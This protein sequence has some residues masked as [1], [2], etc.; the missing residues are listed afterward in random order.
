MGSQLP[1]DGGHDDAD[2][3]VEIQSVVRQVS[4]LPGAY[5]TQADPFNSRPA[6]NAPASIG[7]FNSASPSQWSS[8]V[9]AGLAG[10]AGLP[11]FSDGPVP[12]PHLDFNRFPGSQVH[13]RS[14][15]SFGQQSTSAWLSGNPMASGGLSRNAAALSDIISRTSMYDYANGIDSFGNP[16][17]DRLSEF[18]DYV[19]NAAHDPRISDKELDELLQ[20][21][22]PDMDIPERN[23]DGTPA[24][25]KSSLYHHQELALTWM[26]KM[27]EG[28]NKGG[29]LADDMGL[30]KT[31][32]TLALI[33]SRPATSRPKVRLRMTCSSRFI[34]TN[35]G[36]QTLLL[37][38]LRSFG[39]GRRRSRTRPS[40]HTGCPSFCITTK[41]QRQ[42]TFSSTMWF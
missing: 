34:V 27:E 36:R 32:S 7:G 8:Q 31:I 37:V 6:P 18:T 14:M 11:H 22:H 9:A 41:R 5:P 3:D 1:G 25:L 35:I 28:T 40:S 30:G 19:Q 42:K 13:G 17:S 33:L 23:R 29:I 26:K 21:I 12:G 38:P 20:N 4:T 16:L 15:P 24:G 39:S 2:S 10:N